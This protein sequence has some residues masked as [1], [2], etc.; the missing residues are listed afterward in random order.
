MKAF[1][2][3]ERSAALLSRRD[4]FALALAAIAQVF[5]A[6]LDLMGIVL[7]ALVVAA[8]TGQQEDGTQS[9]VFRFADSVL[10]LDMSSF[11]VAA[12]AAFSLILK[13]VLS[14]IL[15]R[16]TYRFLAHRQAK[17]AERLAE[18]LLTGSILDFQQRSS[19]ETAFALTAGVNAATVNT[20]GPAM[21]IFSEFALVA[22]LSAGLLLLDPLIAV[23]ALSF[24]GALALFLHL[25]LG[26]L[27]ERLGDQYRA[28][29][30]DSVQSLQ[31]ALRAYREISVGGRRA[32]FIGRFV[33]ARWRSA[34]VQADVFVLSQAGK[35][36]F[37]V[38]LV[39]GGALLLAWLGL[40]KGASG[41]LALLAIFLVA[42]SR[43]VPSLLRMQ[44]ALASIRNSAGLAATTFTI[45]ESMTCNRSDFARQSALEISA[46]VLNAAVRA[47]HQGF[48]ANVLLR[49]VCLTYPGLSEPTLRDICLSIVEG[50][51]V[52]LVGPSGSG[53]STLA[54]II[55]GVLDP[56]TG[57]S[58]VSGCPS[59]EAA[60]AWPGAMAYVPQDVAIL[61]GTIR[62]NVALGVPSDQ[63][64]DD[65]V[66]WAL[67][68]VRLSGLVITARDGLHTAVGEHGVNLSG[69]QRQRLGLARA[70]YSRPR[71]LVL[72]E[73]TSALD[74]ETEAT[75]TKTLE[76]LRGQV[77]VVM[78]A[79]RLTTVRNVET[80]VY[81]DRGQILGVGTFE[82]M[83]KMVPAF[84]NQARLLGL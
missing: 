38:G 3:V 70:L 60:V 45:H 24:F 72:D 27:A 53:K 21:V 66:S 54:D 46:Q 26:N 61:S 76:T 43:L 28:A 32:L 83:R 29:D 73:A 47:N 59:R 19:Q 1:I 81:L 79:H 71:L 57:S 68:Q 41:G 58:L 6:L 75:I 40:T 84:G 69:G 65:L 35:Y 2:L 22:I 78:V 50:Q 5:V 11:W 15:I 64:K 34:Q 49:D 36:L 4:R 7:I 18:R 16:M 37:E 80:L 39:V 25:S 77:T 48:R 13:S 23:F 62:E 31:E 33:E 56:T 52:A 51:S 63:I 10:P 20:L 9:P 42:A 82:D 14:L 17:V 12:L 74:A 44:G 30:V 67:E 55:L 8:A